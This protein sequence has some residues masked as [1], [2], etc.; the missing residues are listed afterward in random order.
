MKIKNSSAIS[1]VRYNPFFVTV[2]FN[3]GRKYHY[4]GVTYKTY[5]AVINAE[6]VGK[7]YNSL[8][9]GQYTSLQV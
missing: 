7:A 1:E 4:Y 2:K 6:S 5:K 3:S 9:K 8:I